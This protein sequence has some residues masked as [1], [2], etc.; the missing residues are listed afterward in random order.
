M[1][2]HRW[3]EG[4]DYVF[5]SRLAEDHTRFSALADELARAGV[6]I[7][8]AWTTS[9]VIAAQRA[10]PSVPIVIASSADAVR[11]G[12]IGSLARPGGN[13][14][15]VSWLMTELRRKYPELLREAFPRVSRFGVLWN[16]GGDLLA[17][18]EIETTGRALG[19][20]VES[21]RGADTGR[22]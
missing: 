8:M 16:A 14:T 12:L 22:Y 21:F 19:T 6:S 17:L 20:K 18:R 2:Y 7:I 15:G 9:A 3:T 13:V 1:H 10:A 11:M 5:E 4:R